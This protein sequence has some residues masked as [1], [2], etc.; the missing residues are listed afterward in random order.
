MRIDEHRA[1]A[2]FRRD[3]PFIRSVYCGATLLDD[4]NKMSAA[5]PHL[6]KKNYEQET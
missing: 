6:S 3:L 4:Y 1:L 2:L 5:P